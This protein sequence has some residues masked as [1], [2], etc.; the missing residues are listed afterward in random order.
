MEAGT[1]TKPELRTRH[2]APWLKV[3][4]H[5]GDIYWLAHVLVTQKPVFM[6]R[7]IARGQPLPHGQLVCSSCN[8]TEVSAC[9]TWR[10]CMMCCKHCRCRK[11]RTRCVRC[12]A[13]IA[14]KDISRK[15]PCEVFFHKYIH[16]YIHTY[17]YVHAYIHILYTIKAVF[18]VDIWNSGTKRQPSAK[19]QR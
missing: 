12:P 13:T 17:M 2:K 6:K 5:P 4:N 7:S 8:I 14:V 18:A 15:S 9:S 19:R 11:P 16:T 3:C 10:G 1:A